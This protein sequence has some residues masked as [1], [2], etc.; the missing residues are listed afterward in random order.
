[1]WSSCFFTKVKIFIKIRFW[2]YAPSLTTPYFIKN[3]ILKPLTLVKNIQIQPKTSLPY[4]FP[5]F[6]DNVE[7][8]KCV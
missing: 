7:K 6:V 5:S 2:K 4:F 1:M 8:T 3:L